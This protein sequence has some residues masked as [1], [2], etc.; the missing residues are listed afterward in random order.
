MIKI[1]VIIAAY[2]AELYLEETI[3]SVVNQTLDEYEILVVN[4]GSTDSTADI[5]KK[6]EAMYDNFKGITKENG[7]PSSA[8]NLGL[9]VAQGEYIFFL[10]ADDILEITALENLYLR[11]KETGADLVIAKYD[12]FDEIRSYK[13][14]NINDLVEKKDIEKYDNQILQTFALWNKLFRRELIV[15]HE[16]KFPPISYSEDGA[17]LMEYIYHAEKITGLEEVV[18]HYRRMLESNSIT[19][20]VSKKKVEDYIEAHRLIIQSA[21]NSFLRDYPEYTIWEEAEEGDEEIRDYMQQILLKEIRILLNQFYFK[22]WSLEEDCIDLIVKEIEYRSKMLY[23]K[24]MLQLVNEYPSMA[25]LNLARTYEQAQKDTRIAIALY[26][27]ELKNTEE[28]VRCLQSLMMQNMVY[29]EIYIPEKMRDYLRAE[30]LIRENMIFLDAETEDELFKKVIATTSAPYALF[31]STKFTYIKNAL[32]YAYKKLISTRIDIYAELVYHKNYGE[33]QPVFYNEIPFQVWK[34]SKKESEIYV[35]DAVLENKVYTVDFLRRNVRDDIELRAQ[36][37]HLMQKGYCWRGDNKLVIF[38]EEEDAFLELIE[39]DGIRNRIDSYMKAETDI[40]LENFQNNK[41]EVL[42]KW[43]RWPGDKFKNKLVRKLVSEI[44]KLEVKNRT[45]F[46]TPRSDGKLEGNIAA[47]YDYVEGEKVICARKLP[48]SDITAMKMFYYILTS[49]V[50]V[51]DDYIKYLRY[52]I[53]KPQQRVVQ[54][55]HAAGAFKRF[56]CRGTNIELKIDKATHA[57]YNLICVSSEAVRK[58]YADAFDVD[59]HKVQALGIPRTDDFYKLDIKENMTKR[60]YEKYPQLK[61]KEVILYAPTFRDY[62]GKREQFEPELD[63]QKL[64][65][66]LLRD[67][68]WVICPHPLMKNKIVDKQ[69]DNIMVVRDFST[70]DMMYVSDLLITD[71]SSVIFEYALLKKPMAFFCYDYAYYDRGFYLRYPEDLPGNMYVNQKELTEYLQGE[72]RHVLSEQYQRFRDKYMSACD[73][74]SGERIGK[75]INDYLTNND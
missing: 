40:S 33:I 25:V 45:V 67:Q 27:D 28:F 35:M 47:L 63:F 60:I 66:D 5:V 49:K 54:L 18:L 56:G 11:A 50:I 37:G 42:L 23:M 52:T 10:D 14:N 2:N 64:S 74:H 61:E 3:E 53:L 13:V 73:G 41:V 31:A 22:F 69:Y 26:G 72:N 38:E 12:I 59:V 70:N 36:A 24:N 29:I 44:K 51:S 21:K 9:K 15:K 68:V 19:A 39:D 57:Q 48:H 8:R 62:T 65:E 16:F 75:I 55:W 7:G 43:V 71:Y 6:Y 20:N 4:D 46:F 34:Y 58:I 17:F 32:K 1:S 30:K